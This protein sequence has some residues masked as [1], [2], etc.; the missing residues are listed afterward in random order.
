MDSITESYS[1]L[2]KN[3]HGPK[4]KKSSGYDIVGKENAWFLYGIGILK[5][6]VDKA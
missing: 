4:N 1:E 2:A 5:P 6:L 3:H